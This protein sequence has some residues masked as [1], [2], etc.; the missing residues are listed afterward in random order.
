MNLARA[1][2]EDFILA[3]QMRE[4]GIPL[5]GYELDRMNTA[6][7]GL[8][9]HPGCNGPNEAFN[10][11]SGGAGYIFTVLISNGSDRPLYPAH[12]G[13]DVPWDSDLRLLPDPRKEIRGQRQ[14][15]QQGH[16]RD[17]DIDL[18]IARNNYSFKDPSQS[19]WHR[20]VVINHRLGRSDPVYPGEFVEGLLL[21]VGVLPIPSEYQDGDRLQLHLRVF[22]QRGHFHGKLFSLF[23][24]GP[25]RKISVAKPSSRRSL[26]ITQGVP[27]DNAQHGDKKVG[28]APPLR[29]PNVSV[30]ADPVL[31]TVGVEK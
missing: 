10:L 11:R 25:A 30:T 5:D 15:R 19:I 12:I 26:L 18:A 17:A 7:R 2:Y 29:R 9:I 6:S 20:D 23:V 1:S 27:A 16:K 24:R 31:E 4:R 3:T 22:D 13:F 8:S 21:A 28:A 14:F